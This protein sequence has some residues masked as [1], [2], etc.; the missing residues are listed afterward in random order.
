MTSRGPQEASHA[1]ANVE[2]KQLGARRADL[3]SMSKP[4]AASQTGSTDKLLTRAPAAEVIGV[5]ESTFRR[6]IENVELTPIKD[7]G[8][9]RFAESEVLEV[10]LRYRRD[11]QRGAAHQNG[12]DD[13]GKL[14]A[15]LFTAFDD[16]VSSV[17]AVKRFE[18]DPAI[19]EALHVQWARC[20]GLSSSPPT[21]LAR[22]RPSRRSASGPRVR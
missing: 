15:K 18:L 12:S 22:S 13:R 3:E 10:A 20:A 14:A 16:G 9:H 4:Q 17:D 6:R 7:G 8:V 5:S 2:K 19:V 1:L 21:T 11:R